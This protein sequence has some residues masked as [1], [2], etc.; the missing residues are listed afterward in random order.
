VAASRP[1]TRLSYG[2]VAAGAGGLLLILSLFLDW[3]GGLFGGAVT[4]FE[5][6]SIVDLFLLVVGLLA[7]GFAVVEAMGLQVNLPVDRTRTL[8]I[9]GIIATS[10]VWAFLLEGEHQKIGLILAAIASVAIL[11]GGMLAERNPSLGVANPAAAGGPLAGVTQGG[12]GGGSGPPPAASTPAA[13]PAAAPAQPA[14]QTPTSAGAAASAAPAGGAGAKAD[15]YPDPRG[16][17]RL[18]YW[19]GSQW[20]DHTAD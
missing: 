1:P 4:G 2:A 5:F 20:T 9:L 14:A 18:R 3:Y 8:T 13:T 17:K 6:F 15:W 10:I 11:A 19:D 16:E 7:A 12:G